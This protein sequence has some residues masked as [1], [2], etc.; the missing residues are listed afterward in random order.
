MKRI[1]FE[2]K[3]FENVMVQLREEFEQITTLDTLK[4]FI[5]EC[6][7]NDDF[8]VAAHL[9]ETLLQEQNPDSEWY[10]YD[11]AMGTLETPVCIKSKEDVEHLIE[12]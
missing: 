7:D 1:E 4:S 6:V 3:N 10:D 8:N 9:C 12:D 11:Y 2:Q 5:K